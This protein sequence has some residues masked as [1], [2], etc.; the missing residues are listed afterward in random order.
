MPFRWTQL[1]SFLFS[2]IFHRPGNLFHRQYSSSKDVKLKWIVWLHLVA[3]SYIWQNLPISVVDFTKENLWISNV[4]ALW[5]RCSPFSKWVTFVDFHIPLTLNPPPTH[6]YV[7]PKLP[8]NNPDSERLT[9]QSPSDGEEQLDRLQQAEL[10]RN[11]C[12]SLWRAGA[13]RA[14][15]EVVMGMPMYISA[16]SENVKSGKVHLRYMWLLV[17]E[18]GGW[19]CLI[20]NWM[21]F[22]QV[23]LGLTDEDLEL[24]LGISNPMHHRKLRLAIEDYRRAEGDQGW[25]AISK[26]LKW[27]VR[28]RGRIRIR[29]Q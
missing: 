8:L 15:L 10:T 14:W 24:G 5:F 11:T 28:S 1:R 7:T 13:V 26:I 25:A 3:I 16:C 12:M 27:L 20:T 2:F 18:S 6:P 21:S 23:L 17:L 22:L 9:Q 29:A 19:W 4:N